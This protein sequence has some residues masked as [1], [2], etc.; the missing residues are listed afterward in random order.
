MH[1]WLCAPVLTV[2]EANAQFGR[3]PHVLHHSSAL[4]GPQLTLSVR[5]HKTKPVSFNHLA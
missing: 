2:G 1:T 5:P 3:L 4:N